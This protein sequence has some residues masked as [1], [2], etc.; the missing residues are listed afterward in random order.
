MPVNHIHRTLHEVF[1]S[2]CQSLARSSGFCQ[3]QSRLSASAW[4]QGLVFGW[5]SNPQAS[6]TRLASAIAVAGSSVSPQAVQQ[7]FSCA[8]A[9]LLRGVLDILAGHALQTGVRQD[10][11]R[12]Q[13]QWLQNFPAIWLRDSSLITLPLALYSQWP[14]SGGHHGP[15]A[16]LKVSV[17]WEW[18]SGTL[19]PLHLTPA[20][21]HD[22]KAARE[23]EDRAHQQ[24]HGSIPGEMHVFD[25][26]YFSLEWLGHLHAQDAYFCCRYKGATHVQPLHA[27]DEWASLVLWLEAIPPHQ[28]RVEWNVLLG[29]H[30][31][32]SVRVIAVRVPE[33]VAVQRRQACLYYNGR[34]Q[35]T[36][37]PERLALCSWNV[38]VT[39]APKTLLTAA[40][41]SVLYRVRWQIER[42]F[43]LWKETLQI[44]QWRTQNP[45]RI[46]CEVYAKLIGALLTQQLTVFC[47]WHLPNRSLVKCAHI[48]AGHALALLIH[49]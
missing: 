6:V 2:H 4:V 21:Q 33:A 38:Y 11:P 47:A 8:G 23:Q 48:I 16:A 42:L 45:Q 34:R 7:R 13:C 12:S 15:S 18:H 28:E 27:P 22:Q 9:T 35:R 41:V 46:L 30:A 36:V 19:L 37:S 40:Q 31:Q 10:L 26:G 5:L 43:R 20:T 29:R 39:N 3:R 14:G 17:Q 44:D 1:V 32:L 49:L 25:L 24:G